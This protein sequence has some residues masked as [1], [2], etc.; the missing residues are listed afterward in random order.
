[1]NRSIV[2]LAQALSEA[3][4]LKISP[5]GLPMFCRLPQIWTY[6]FFGNQQCIG[7]VADG[8]GP[9]GR[10]PAWQCGGIIDL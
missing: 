7:V 4:R 3:I 1:M 6:C 2:C 8:G 5:S 10:I 9:C